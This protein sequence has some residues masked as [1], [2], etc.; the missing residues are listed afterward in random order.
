MEPFY[1]AP[2]G[3]VNPFE[4]DN[5]APDVPSLPQEVSDI[6]QAV[7]QVDTQKAAAMAPT[8]RQLEPAEQENL[9]KDLDILEFLQG[10]KAESAV[11]QQKQIGMSSPF[12]KQ[13][14]NVTPVTQVE[15]LTDIIPDDMPIVLNVLS[16]S[17]PSL[18]PT[19]MLMD[20][21]D[22]AFYAMSVMQNQ[23][24]RSDLKAPLIDSVM[25]NGKFTPNA[26]SKDWYAIRGVELRQSQMMPPGMM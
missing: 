3:D 10:F 5:I 25:R 19:A 26:L 2:I 6:Q 8:M 7:E 24:L 22:R 17:F 9:K 21:A 1:D 16:Q 12:A 20:P 14:K 4:A 13:N 11:E 15:G 23:E 18:T